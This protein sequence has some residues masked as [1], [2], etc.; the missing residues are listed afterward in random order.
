LLLILSAGLFRASAEA[1]AFG[2]EPS[3]FLRLSRLFQLC[4]H[5]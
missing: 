5:I 3:V 2:P 1:V 4:K